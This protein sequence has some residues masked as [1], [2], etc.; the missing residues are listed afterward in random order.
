M[1]TDPN[2]PVVDIE[3]HSLRLS[4]LDKVLYPE[5]GFTKGEVIDFY[6]AMAPVLLPHVRDRPLTLK[7]FPDGV[8]ATSFFEKNVA[9]HAP[10][11]VRT[12]RIDTPGSSRGAEY[13]DFALVQDLPTL[14]WTANLASLELHVP[15]WTVGP[16]GGVREPDLLVFDL[17]P[18]QPATIVEC[19]RV[20][21]LLREALA[22]DGFEAYPKTSGSK[23]M[24]LYSP[25][26]TNDSGHPREYARRLA[27]R[28]ENDHPDLV[29]SRMTKKLREGKVLIDWSQ[30][31]PQKTT[32]APY[33]LRARPHP[34]VSIP[35]AWNEVAHCSNQVDLTF[36]AA[37]AK[38]RVASHGD[39]F[40]PLLGGERPLLRA[41]TGNHG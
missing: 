36:T 32:V 3:G 14:V 35:L 25:I 20:A 2:N 40:E 34:T 4:N 39:L 15:Q 12:V 29:V 27:Q 23:G 19:C 22:D 38:D 10:D 33:S 8:E 6:A 1:S 24:Q 11:W 17:D 30:N 21:E 37:D 7:R 28:L 9:R 16:R 41:D 5:A 13:A 26:R 18:G 31:N